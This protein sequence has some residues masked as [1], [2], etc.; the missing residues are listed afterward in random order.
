MKSGSTVLVVD[1]GGRGAV[2]VEKYAQSPHVSKII[3]VPGND[4]MGINTDKEVE[5]HPR[6]ATTDVREIVGLCV[7]RKVAL[8][9]VA[10]DRAVAAGLVDALEREGIPTVGPCQLAGQIEWDKAW[11]RQFMVRHGIPHP[12]F[13]VFRSADEGEQFLDRQPERAWFVKAAGLAEG[14]GALPAGSNFEAMERIEE[15]SQFGE[16]GETYLLEEWLVGEEFSLFAVC[17]GHSFQVLGNAQDHKRAYNFDEGENTGGMG[18]SSP[19]L[20]LRDE[21]VHGVEEQVL[22]PVVAGLCAEGRPYKGILYLGGM[23]LENGLVSVI[24]FNARWG[25]PEAQVILPGLLADWFELGLAVAEGRVESCG[26]ASDGKARVSVAGV[27]RGYPRSHSSATGRR[28]FGIDEARRLPGVRVYGAG[29]T[30]RVD[31]KDYAAGGR[32]FHI[33]GEGRTVIEARERAYSAL[34]LISVEG[35]NLHYRTDIG[36][37]DVERLRAASPSDLLGTASGVRTALR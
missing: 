23:V 26:V 24:E 27:S 20:L 3:A 36:W 35:N 15:M 30:R 10:Q 19:A 16:A 1:G 18:C 9:D 5:L 28:V 6:L 32:L 22:K 29:V 21:I 12:A 31:G 8:V 14:K 33:V 37:R 11:A 2:L 25:D 34:S 7:D 4:L 13:H 17:D